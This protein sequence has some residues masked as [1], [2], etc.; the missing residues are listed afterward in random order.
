MN[1]SFLHHGSG[2]NYLPN[3]AAFVSVS[4]AP[5]SL[6]FPNWTFGQTFQLIHIDNG[7]K[8]NQSGYIL[9]ITSCYCIKDNIYV[10]K[11]F[12][13]KT[14]NSFWKLIFFDFSPRLFDFHKLPHM[15]SLIHV[16]HSTHFSN[17]IKSN[18]QC[19]H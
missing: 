17:L 15:K 1:F 8:R 5:Y 7:Y 19:Y 11:I 9:L 16:E 13:S 6:F 14:S 12:L 3:A 4:R 2:S 18:C 10:T